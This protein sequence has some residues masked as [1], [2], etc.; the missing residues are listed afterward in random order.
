MLVLT[1]HIRSNITTMA[2][3]HSFLLRKATCDKPLTTFNPLTRALALCRATTSSRCAT[4][5]TQ[6]LF[7][8][9]YVHVW[10]ATSMVQW[11]SWTNFGSKGT[12][13]LISSLQSSGWW[14]PLTSEFI[15][16]FALCCACWYWLR[17]NA[18]IHKI[19]VYQGP[20]PVLYIAFPALDLVPSI[21][22]RLH[23]HARI[24]GCRYT[25]PARWTY[26]ASLQDG[27]PISTEHV[28]IFVLMKSSQNVKPELFRV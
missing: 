8:L 10:K 16:K 26:G 3:R 21:G 1:V 20:W 22:N 4:S 11:R 13:Q 2:S 15:T 19:G 9:Q 27:R 28:H 14:R 18:W 7:R 23:T 25:H 24:G 12:V 5:R 17:K 6:L